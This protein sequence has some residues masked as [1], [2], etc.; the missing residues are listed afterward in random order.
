MLVPVLVHNVNARPLLPGWAN[1]RQ[2]QDQIITRLFQVRTHC[3]F[4]GAVIS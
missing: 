2:P 3:S 4:G 1:I